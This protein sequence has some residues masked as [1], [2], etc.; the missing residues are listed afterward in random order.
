MTIPQTHDSIFQMGVANPGI[1]DAAAH[2]LLEEAAAASVGAPGP[3]EK[4]Q[5]L[6]T[7]V[8]IFYGRGNM[9][10]ILAFSGL[11]NHTGSQAFNF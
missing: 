4:L 2:V 11:E 9:C 10:N 8:G 6:L 7:K 3:V 1:R 5:V